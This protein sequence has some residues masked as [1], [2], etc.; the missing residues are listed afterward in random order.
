MGAMDYF[1]KMSS[2][3]IFPVAMA[4]VGV[5]YGCSHCTLKEEDRAI[6]LKWV[7]KPRNGLIKGIL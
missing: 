4:C 2:K 3:D 7:G 5:L 1:Q 6:F